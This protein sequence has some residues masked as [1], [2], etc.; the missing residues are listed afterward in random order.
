MN[1]RHMVLF[2]GSAAIAAA[3][4]LPETANA[5]SRQIS[6][7]A[8]MANSSSVTMW[9]DTISAADVYRPY[10]CPILEDTNLSKEDITTLNVT[11]HDGSTLDRVVAKACVLDS[12][13]AFF[14]GS[15]GT[16]SGSGLTNEATG[17]FTLSPSRM[18]WNALNDD[19]YAYIYITVPSRFA[20]SDYSTVGGI[21]YSD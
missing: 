16:T 6:G 15:C 7:H 13:S 14:S 9:R 1:I 12:F 3:V 20:P 4:S 21:Y 5:F 17:N 18:Y 19:D 2:A 10:Y 11:V 8:C